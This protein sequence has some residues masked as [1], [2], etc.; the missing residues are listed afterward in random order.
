MSYGAGQDNQPI[1]PAVDV[2]ILTA[3]SE[4]LKYVI[5][6]FNRCESKNE[7]DWKEKYV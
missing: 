3:L 2:C 4:E 5:Y 1:H 6:A 7:L